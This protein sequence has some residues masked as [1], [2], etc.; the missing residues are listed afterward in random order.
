MSRH[1]SRVFSG[2]IFSF[3]IVS[4][5][6]SCTK[7]APWSG[8][9][10]EKQ[11][12]PGE[13]RLKL[14]WMSLDGL[15]PEALEPWVSKLKNPH[16]K[17][18]SWLLRSA[19][20]RADLK[21]INPT[22][23]APSHISTITCAG[24]GAHGIMDNSTW[25]GN[26]TTSGFNKPYAPENWITRLKKQGM[27]IGSSLYPSIDG[28]G[29]GRQADV[30]IFY[31]NPGSTPQLL[32]VA[33]GA[34]MGASIPDRSQST[35]GYPVE[36]SVSAE[37]V[38]SVKTPW[39][40][41]DRLSPAT[42][43]DVLF[44]TTIAGAERKA[45]VSFMLVAT[46]PDVTVE[47]SPIQVMPVMGSEFAS[48]LDRKD[49]IFSSLRDYRIQS[50]V[51]AYLASMEHRRRFVV[52]TDAVMLGRVD[53]DAVFLYFEDLDALLHAYYRDDRNEGL[54][55]DYLAKFDQDVGRLLSLIPANTDF[56]A[57][58]DHGMSAISYV[59][60]A[61]KVLTE[62]VASKGTVMAGG[63]ALYLYPPQGDLAQDPPKD[64]DLNAVA[65]SLRA[66]ELDLTG[67][68]LFGKVI[69]RGSKEAA[70]EG[71]SGNQ[72]PWIMAFANEGVGFKN[73][74]EDKMLL[75]RKSVV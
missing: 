24:A 35:K 10:Q 25:T 18:L 28:S 61:R 39:G 29:T 69:V 17:G 23:T 67:S 1:V 13:S 66:M 8:S 48:T 65:E 3:A 63:G 5:S 70:E 47:V 33:K 34:T 41:V 27:R 30:G 56:V 4:S 42:P 60:N 22:I 59:L 38:V 75:D 54:I 46:T 6:V 49:I 45:A 20:G 73:S 32:T 51:A 62:A 14:V 19:R 55:I 57:L 50:N 7:V 64:L 11:V 37:G 36:I 52:E 74:V 53:L 9:D 43:V 58:G 16:P 40:N 15:Q 68:K 31:D 71:L 72:V 21:V 2:I 12:V 26:G 44:T